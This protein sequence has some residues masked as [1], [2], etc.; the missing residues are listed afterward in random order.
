M[1]DY[2][3]T[4]K[5]TITIVASQTEY[6]IPTVANRNL[7]RV[8][9]QTKKDTNDYR[10]IKVHGWDIERTAVGTADLLILARQL[11]A[12]YLLRLEYGDVHDPLYVSTDQLT[13]TVHVMRVVTLA[14]IKCLLHRKQKIGS[15]DPTLNEQLNMFMDE[16]G[17]WRAEE[18]TKEPEPDHKLFIIRGL[19]R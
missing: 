1:G 16:L 7:I 5:A 15:N 17:M 12:G 19:G 14:S 10:W 18:P 6:S 3:V 11:T 4:D 13:E 8:S 9:V 2:P